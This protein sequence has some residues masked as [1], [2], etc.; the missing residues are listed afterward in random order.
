MSK[1]FNTTLRINLSDPEG[2]K[3]GLISSIGISPD[4]APT[5]TPSSP[6]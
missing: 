2:L 5:A 6:L 1:L 4:T 3:A